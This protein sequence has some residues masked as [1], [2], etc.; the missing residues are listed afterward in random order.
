VLFLELREAKVVAIGQ[1]WLAVLPWLRVW[2]LLF[3]IAGMEWLE[4]WVKVH[5]FMGL[6]G[7]WNLQ[8]S[9]NG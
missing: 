5:G 6:F 3:V 2:K 4:R 1:W 9:W 7:F 8:V